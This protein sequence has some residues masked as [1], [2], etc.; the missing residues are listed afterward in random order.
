MCTV[1]AGSE[2]VDVDSVSVSVHLENVN[3]SYSCIQLS[4]LQYD[5]TERQLLQR[6]ENAALCIQSAYRRHVARKAYLAQQWSVAVLHRLAVG[7]LYSV[8]FHVIR[9]AVITLQAAFRRHVCRRRYL[10]LHAAVCHI[11]LSIVGEHAT[12]ATRQCV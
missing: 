9:G 2:N 5:D 12:V 8:R 4:T 7:Y 1:E 3:L 10:L 6:T 11:Q